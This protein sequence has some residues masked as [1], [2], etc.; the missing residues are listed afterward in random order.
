MGSM[1]LHVQQEGFTEQ[2]V[3]NRFLTMAPPQHL[4]EPEDLPGQWC[5][6]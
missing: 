2:E 1:R 6:W 4:T 3:L 5:T